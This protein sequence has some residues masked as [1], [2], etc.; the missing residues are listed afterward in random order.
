MTPVTQHGALTLDWRGDEVARAMHQA[1][2]A[3]V[4]ATLDEAVELARQDAPV[5][6]GELRDGIQRFG[7][8]E[9]ADEGAA[10]AWGGSAPHTLFVEI[11]AR[12]RSGVHM[13]RR[14]ADRAY[15]RLSARIAEEFQRRAP[16]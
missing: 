13:L 7:A 8:V 10:G 12:G 15:P 3:A 4:E 5:R 2:E 11:G 1:E 14:A 16:R 6:T 9:G